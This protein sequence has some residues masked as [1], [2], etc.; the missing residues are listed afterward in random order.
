M[1]NISIQHDQVSAA[2]AD[3]HAAHADALAALTPPAV[4][5]GVPGDVLTSIASL[6]AGGRKIH[7]NAVAIG[8]LGEAANRALESTDEGNAGRFKGAEK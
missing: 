5:G 7:E 4:T 2:L 8:R 3:H 6:L 1:S